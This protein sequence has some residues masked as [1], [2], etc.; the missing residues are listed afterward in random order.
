MPPR[1]ADDSKRSPG[2]GGIKV[3]ETEDLLG[4][5]AQGYGTGAH[6]GTHRLARSRGRRRP[7]NPI[8]S[9]DLPANDP[10]LPL[11]GESDL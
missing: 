1:A 4:F 8:G 6:G 11:Q 10:P 2:G 7:R 3:A 5:P 9:T